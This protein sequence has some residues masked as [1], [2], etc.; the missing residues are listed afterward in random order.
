MKTYIFF[1]V[2]LTQ[3]CVCVGMEKPG[4]RKLYYEIRSTNGQPISEVKKMKCDGEITVSELKHVLESLH[5]NYA[6]QSISLEPYD[7]DNH[8]LR[9]QYGENWEEKAEKRIDEL[10]NNSDERAKVAIK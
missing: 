9:F 8:A 7:K 2:A 4:K 6:L 5:K 10:W 3:C 1:F